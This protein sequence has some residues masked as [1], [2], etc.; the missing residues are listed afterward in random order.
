MGVGTDR[1]CVGILR[2]G[3]RGVSMR[4]HN[5]RPPNSWS[6]LRGTECCF[7][8]ARTRFCGTRVRLPGSDR[9]LPGGN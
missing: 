3:V 1:I 7:P 5:V 6:C 9:S 2:I 4:A 8:V